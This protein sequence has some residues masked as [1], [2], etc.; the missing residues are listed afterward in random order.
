MF[1]PAVVL[2]PCESKLCQSHDRCENPQE[3]LRLRRTLA[4]VRGGISLLFCPFS[5]FFP[6]LLCLYL[7]P[8]SPFFVSFFLPSSLFHCL[9]F[10]VFVF[11]FPLAV[12]ACVLNIPSLLSINVSL[13]TLSLFLSGKGHARVL[14]SGCC[15]WIQLKRI[16]IN[17]GSF[18]ILWHVLGAEIILLVPAYLKEVLTVQN[19]VV[20]LEDAW[21]SGGIISWILNIG[22]K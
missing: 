3:P 8:F 13:Q 19:E 21:W 17:L 1:F 6:S 10:G 2:M 18:S 22:I 5:F 14:S 16:F 11:F 20:Y 15:G 12:F 9:L 7:H 4:R